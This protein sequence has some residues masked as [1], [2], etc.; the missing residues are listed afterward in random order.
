MNNIFNH[1][2]HPGILSN[3]TSC[4][5][6]CVRMYG[7]W[8]RLRNCL[9]KTCR[10]STQSLVW[11]AFFFFDMLF[12]SINTTDLFLKERHKGG[13]WGLCSDRSVYKQWSVVSWSQAIKNEIHLRGSQDKSPY[14]G[15]CVS[16][17]VWSMYG[18]DHTFRLP[19]KKLMKSH[20][21]VNQQ[22]GSWEECCFI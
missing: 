16:A 5:V 2:N 20:K 4:R 10:F 1:V 8:G 7:N 3:P 17:I 18:V 13:L 6:V 11:S 22:N 15:R 12:T 14:I 21:N 19:K 9:C